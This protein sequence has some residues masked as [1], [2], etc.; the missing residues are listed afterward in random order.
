MTKRSFV[1]LDIPKTTESGTTD[2]SSKESR[3]TE[4]KEEDKATD[5]E[6]VAATRIQAAFRGHHA[7]KSMKDTENSTKQS[8]SKSDSEPT[9]EQLQEEFRSDDKGKF[10]KRNSP[11][12]FKKIPHYTIKRSLQKRFFENRPTFSLFFFSLT[13][14]ITLH[15]L[16]AV[17]KKVNYL[18]SILELNQCIS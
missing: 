7:R 11:Q 12:Q 16:L 1:D 13:T 4:Q 9:L 15:T 10:S 3:Q 6:E 2:V 18:L 14:K 17:K 5:K 8:E